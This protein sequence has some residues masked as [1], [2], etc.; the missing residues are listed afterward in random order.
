MV[1]INFDVYLKYDFKPVN[2]YDNP[3][4]RVSHTVILI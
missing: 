3:T 4:R 2:I 1:K